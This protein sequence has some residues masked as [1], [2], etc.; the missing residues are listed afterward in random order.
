LKQFITF[1]NEL[2]FLAVMGTLLPFLLLLIQKPT[3]LIYK[4]IYNTEPVV[5]KP[6]PTIDDAVYSLILLFVPMVLVFVIMLKLL[7]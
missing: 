7:K 4:S 1:D 3:R 2:A 5:D 6:A